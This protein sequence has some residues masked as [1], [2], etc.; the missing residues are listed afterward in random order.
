MVMAWLHIVGCRDTMC[1]ACVCV[2]DVRVMGWQ[3]AGSRRCWCPPRAACS[4]PRCLRRSR[5][6]CCAHASKPRRRRCKGLDS[7]QWMRRGLLVMMSTYWTL[8]SW[9]MVRGGL[10]AFV[11]GLGLG[12]GLGLALRVVCAVGVKYNVLY[13]VLL[14]LPCLVSALQWLCACERVRVCAASCLPS[15][16]ELSPCMM[17]ACARHHSFCFFWGGGEQRQTAPF[18]AVSENRRRKSWWTPLRRWRNRSSGHLQTRKSS[19]GSQRSGRCSASEFLFA[20]VALLLFCCCFLSACTSVC[21][22]WQC[23]QPRVLLAHC[24]SRGCLA[25]VVRCFPTSYATMMRGQREDAE[26]RL[27]RIRSERGAKQA[28]LEHLQDARLVTAADEA[29]HDASLEDDAA[30]DGVMTAN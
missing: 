25:M 2:C 22:G 30:A 27:A 10:F 15:S 1:G 9:R 21:A 12:L 16:C 8:P 11:F 5:S 26:N 14:L 3:V 24:I 4:V 20:V 7:R 18:L 13:G 19:G 23:F 6:T 28:Q 17:L 29:G